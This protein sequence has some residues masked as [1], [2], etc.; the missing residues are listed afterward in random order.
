MKI[1]R[2]AVA[3]TLFMRAKGDLSLFLSLAIANQVDAIKWQYFIIVPLFIAVHMYWSDNRA[4]RQE[5][6]YSRSKSRLFN[7]LLDRVKHI[8]NLLDKSSKS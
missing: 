4:I 1:W 2:S 3:K 5:A 8:E 7:E 6:D